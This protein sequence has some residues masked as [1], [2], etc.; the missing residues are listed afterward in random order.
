MT[1]RLSPRER[2]TVTLITGTKT[3]D[4]YVM[5]ADSQ[6]TVGQF[7]VS[8]LKLSP[9]TAGNFEI[10]FA[11]S[12]NNGRLIDAFEDRFKAALQGNTVGS[13]DALKELIHREL[14]DFQKTEAVAYPRRERE[15]RLLIGARANLHSK[16]ILWATSASRLIPV[17]RFE[18]IGFE[19]ERY[20]FAAEAYLRATAEITT[21]QGIFLGLYI[22]WL[23][24]QTSNYVKAPVNVIVVRDGGIFTEKQSKIDA[25]LERVKVFSAQ[26]DRIF[27]ACPDTGL[28]PSDFVS[29]L[30]EFVKSIV[31][32]RQE[33]VEEWVG[34]AVSDGLDKII[35]PY[36]LIAPGTTIIVNP[37]PEQA[38]AQHNVQTRLSDAL[39]HNY[40][41]LQEIDQ[42]VSNL[43]SLRNYQRKVCD[44]CDGHGEGPTD[45]D[46]ARMNVAHGKVF[47]AALM[48]AWKVDA[49]TCNLLHHANGAMQRSGED[50]MGYVSPAMR[51]ATE[52][53]RLA[54]VERALA[55]VQRPTPIDSQTS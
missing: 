35:D 46:T 52:R 51:A 37:T 9:W 8:R 4:G 50:F 39:R 27:L 13:L 18:L 23:A 34:Q 22:M 45:A 49:E 38:A 17:T 29:R 53:L 30:N 21:A 28:Q 2:E 20:R 55:Y 47:Q 41:F 26:F 16:S 24:E 14:L 3:N 48:G 10:A 44:Q 32:L 19:D 40:S 36:P 7:R 15:M 5:C 12:G 33:Y 42:L 25:L 11:G 1:L 31:H 43:E 54:I 6:E